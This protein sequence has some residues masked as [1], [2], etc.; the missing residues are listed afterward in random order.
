MEQKTIVIKD[1]V[2]SPNWIQVSDGAKVYDQI[3]PA[4]KAGDKVVLSFSGRT[5]VITAFLNAAIGK[6]Y[7]G[8][9]SE[10]DISLLTYANT[11]ASDNDK[12][13]RVIANAKMYYKN[14]PQY[15]DALFK[16]EVE[17]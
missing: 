3:Q 15:R 10:A 5:F 7:N 1:V 6:L 12:I 2:G 13:Q 14:N 4:I 11:D 16:R 17:A 9:F 8:Q